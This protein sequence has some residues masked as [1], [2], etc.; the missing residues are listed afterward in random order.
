MFESNVFDFF[1]EDDIQKPIQ[2]KAIIGPD[3]IFDHNRFQAC[4]VGMRNG[5]VQSKYETSINSY[6]VKKWERNPYPSSDFVLKV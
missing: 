4:Q 5:Q 1:S 6:S 3:L 2:L